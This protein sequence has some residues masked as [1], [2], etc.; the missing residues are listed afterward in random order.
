MLGAWS[1]CLRPRRVV[2]SQPTTRAPG[3]MHKQLHAKLLRRSNLTTLWSRRPEVV[4]GCCAGT[5]LTYLVTMPNGVR[6]L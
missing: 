5:I 4:P 3:L 2:D 6:A 1:K